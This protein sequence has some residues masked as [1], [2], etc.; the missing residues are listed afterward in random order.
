MQHD[1]ELDDLWTRFE[2]AEGYWIGH[3]RVANCQAF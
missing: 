2:I 3:S 1:C